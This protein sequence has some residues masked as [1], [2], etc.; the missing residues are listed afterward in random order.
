MGKN[1]RTVSVPF[2][3]INRDTV[4]PNTRKSWETIVNIVKEMFGLNDQRVI[5][6]NVIYDNRKGAPEINKR[7][8][9]LKAGDEEWEVTH[10]QVVWG[11]LEVLFRNRPLFDPFTGITSG[12]ESGPSVNVT[13]VPTN[14]RRYSD[15]LHLFTPDVHRYWKDMT[16]EGF[17]HNVK[18][19]FGDKVEITCD[20]LGDIINLDTVADELKLSG[21]VPFDEA[22]LISVD[23]EKST[24]F[25]NE[26]GKVVKIHVHL[27]HAVIDNNDLK[28]FFCFKRVK[29]FDELTSNLNRPFTDHLKGSRH[30]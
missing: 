2:V 22:I 1:K 3:S 23:D 27:S 6:G 28:N 8:L 13:I 10:F 7:Q 17:H 26:V 11:N 14:L 19:L 30:E 29:S 5:V 21:R 18:E 15:Q 20:Y 16:V 4:F 25:Y 24:V 12:K 9:L